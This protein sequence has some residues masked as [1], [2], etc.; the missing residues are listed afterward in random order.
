MP[1]M[2]SQINRKASEYTSLTLTSMQLTV[3]SVLLSLA[4]E[5][6]ILLSYLLDH[7]KM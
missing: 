3:L 6:P 7:L 5:I 4:N 1:N 2:L